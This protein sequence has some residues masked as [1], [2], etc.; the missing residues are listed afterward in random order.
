MTRLDRLTQ[1]MKADGVKAVVP[2]LTAGYPALGT[3]DSLVG[4]VARSGCRLME[5]GI[6]FSDP[7]ADGPVI[8]ASSQVALEQGVNLEMVLEMAGRAGRA[9]DLDVVLMG[10]LN[11]VLHFGAEKFARACGDQEVAG[12]I[13]PD[14]PSEEAGPL[15]ALLKA[16]DVALVDLVAPTTTD[17]RLGPMVSEAAGFLYLV[18]VTGVTGSGPEGSSDITDYLQRVASATDLPRYVGFGVSS[19]EQAAAICR[20]ADGVIIGSQLIRLIE[21]AESF[22]HASDILEEFLVQVNRAV[23][24]DRKE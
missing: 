24:P 14:L 8:Q 7:V 15:R 9:H 3:F 18:S 1:K 21:G 19:P 12:L 13:I 10:Y 2:F 11:P 6:P 17:E 22:D 5:I 4:A 20:H 23:N 16:N